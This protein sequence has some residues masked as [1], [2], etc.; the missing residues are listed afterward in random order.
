MQLSFELNLDRWTDFFTLRDL[1]LHRR[2]GRAL[3]QLEC[4]P[5]FD[6]ELQKYV[7][8]RVQKE[9]ASCLN[10]KDPPLAEFDRLQ[11]DAFSY[12]AFYDM[13]LEKKPILLSALTGSVS[14]QNF[15]LFRVSSECNLIIS[16]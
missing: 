3:K 2:P 9:A 14:N 1:I 11:I 6:Q 12:E 4:L 10:D 8:E 16:S 15:D 7:Y 13:I 5:N